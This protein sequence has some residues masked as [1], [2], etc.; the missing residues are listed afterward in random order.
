MTYLVHSRNYIR[1]SPG[2]EM[3]HDKMHQDD[4][5]ALEAV[6]ILGKTVDIFSRVFNNLIVDVLALFKDFKR[7]ELRMIHQSYP[8][9]LSDLWKQHHIPLQNIQVAVPTGMIGTYHDTTQ[10]LGILLARLNIQATVDVLERYFHQYRAV[11]PTD[12][13]QTFGESIT[14]TQQSI[15]NLSKTDL[16][17]LLHPC[18]KADGPAETTASKVF[19]NLEDIKAVDAKLLSYEVFFKQAQALSG[20]IKNINVEASKIIDG[21]TANKQNDPVYLKNLENLLYTAAE[22][23]DFYGVILHE[24]LRVE[25]NFCLALRRMFETV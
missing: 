23:I 9:R 3:L 10:T 20:R 13:A 2:M 12:Y 8:M 19:R 4:V 17:S 24:I 11:R 5:T 6:G 1:L 14:K 18:F 25:H 16:E 15:T 22:Q 7:S 21:L